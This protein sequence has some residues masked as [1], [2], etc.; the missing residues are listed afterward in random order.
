MN[1]LLREK[2]KETNNDS[3]LVRNMRQLRLASSSVLKLSIVTAISAF[4]E[5][6]TYLEIFSTWASERSNKCHLKLRNSFF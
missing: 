6:R 5:N 3:N 1:H 2:N 4:V